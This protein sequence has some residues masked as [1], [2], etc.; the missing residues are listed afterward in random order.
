MDQEEDRTPLKIVKIMASVLP[1]LLK[2]GLLY[3]SYKK[4]VKKRD[5]IMKKELR[6]VGM[7]K[8]MIDEMCK[9]LDVITI[10]DLMSMGGSSEIFD[11]IP[12]F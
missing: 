5:K 4:R 7:D 3:L 12:F 11:K 9:N 8:K 6:R 1:L 2:I 10:R